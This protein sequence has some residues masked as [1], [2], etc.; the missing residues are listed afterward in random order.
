MTWV[1]NMLK[2]DVD[3]KECLLFQFMWRHLTV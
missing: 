3:G 1:Y 2:L